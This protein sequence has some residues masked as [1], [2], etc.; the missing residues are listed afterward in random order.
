M[1][2]CVPF[3]AIAQVFQTKTNYLK[4]QMSSKATG[5]TNVNP[6]RQEAANHKPM[7]QFLPVK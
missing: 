6:G 3:T 1:E 7:L 2:P 5:K 4:Q